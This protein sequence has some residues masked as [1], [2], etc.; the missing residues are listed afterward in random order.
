MHFANGDAG[1]V[2]SWVSPAFE[3]KTVVAFS[4]WMFWRLRRVRILATDVFVHERQVS[5][6]KMPLSL[7]VVVWS[8]EI[9]RDHRALIET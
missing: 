1:E 6:R 7:R 4:G 8:R 3:N 2:Q 5:G 9:I